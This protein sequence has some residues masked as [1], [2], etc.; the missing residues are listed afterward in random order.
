MA[1]K[2]GRQTNW[3][4]CLPIAG[5][6]WALGDI[7]NGTFIENNMHAKSGYMTRVRSYTGYVKNKSG[8]ILCFSMIAN[9]YSCTP[10]TMKKKFEKLLIAISN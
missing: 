2:D 3:C 5:V 7:G 6:S 10:A 8:H 1:I 4:N 9:N